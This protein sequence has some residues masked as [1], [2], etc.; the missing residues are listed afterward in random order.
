MTIKNSVLKLLNKWQ[1]RDFILDPYKVS[2]VHK[3]IPADPVAHINFCRWML[4]SVLDRTLNPTLLFTRNKAWFHFSGFVNSQN[5]CHCDT[6]YPH[7]IHNVPLHDKKW[8]YGVWL[9]V[10]EELGPYFL[11][12]GELQALCEQYSGTVLS[13]AHCRREAMCI[14]TAE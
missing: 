3:L 9:V 6:K 4:Q 11:W 1:Q 13:Y 10:G 5:T 7:I 8:V 12:H 14:F 2:V